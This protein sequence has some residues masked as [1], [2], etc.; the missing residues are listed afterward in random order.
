MTSLLRRKH[1]TTHRARTTPTRMPASQLPV[2]SCQLS[3]SSGQCSVAS[4]QKTPKGLFS[5]ATGPWPLITLLLAWAIFS[6]LANT[7][8][9]QQTG[10][11]NRFSP[12]TPPDLPVEYL[13]AIAPPVENKAGVVQPPSG[14]TTPVS[15]VLEPRNNEEV[16][17]PVWKNGKGDILPIQYMN[18]RER[19]DL[20]FTQDLPGPQRLFRRESE[21]QFQER[22]RLESKRFGGAKVHFPENPV[23]SREPLKPR[24][25]EPSVALV[26]PCYVAHGRLLFEQPN[27]ERYGWNLGL[28][29]TVVNAGVYYY[30]LA[31][32]P[33]HIWSRPLDQMDT[34]AGKYLPG[35]PVPLVVYPESFS[36]TG[37]AG[38]AGTYVAGPFIF[39]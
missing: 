5:L 13:P 15:Q 12:P 29:T 37:L 10:V 31:T 38:M 39:H 35:D 24:Q 34:S 3:V 27:F 25:F 6:G 1:Q 7:A 26:H 8:V 20:D 2:A 32:L 17:Y 4:G 16:S 28:L 11:P 21:P 22:I 18:S 19:E 14:P 23:I 33:Y 36:L 9:A 30:D